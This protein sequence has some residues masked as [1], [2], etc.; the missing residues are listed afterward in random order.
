V[1][2]LYEEVRAQGYPRSQRTLTR[3]LRPWRAAS[4]AGE[5]VPPDGLLFRWRASL[6][7][8]EAG[9]ADRYL[10][11]NPGLKSA[12]HLKE[13]FRTAIAMKTVDAL[14]AWLSATEASGFP[15]FV[16]LARSMRRDYD[17]VGAAFISKW[18][19][20]QCKGQITRVKLKKRIGYGRA[21][22]DLLRAR[23]LHREP[24]A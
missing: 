21:K 1:A 2:R 5:A 16:R 22:P 8:D 20:G 19:T 9:R 14:D 3:A 24:A 12:H 11:M 6:T 10:D 4:V 15:S 23:V 7:E 17:A 18:S 13:S